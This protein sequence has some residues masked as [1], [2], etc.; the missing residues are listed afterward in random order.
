M[1]T[2]ANGSGRIDIKLFKYLFC[3]FRE[4]SRIYVV[5]YLVPCSY[6]IIFIY[7]LI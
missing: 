4:H 7:F 3:P 5:V 6:F 2:F 1:T